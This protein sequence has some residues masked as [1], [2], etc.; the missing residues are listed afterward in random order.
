MNAKD[1]SAIAQANKVIKLPCKPG[2][3]FEDL[4]S[5]GSKAKVDSLLLKFEELA[6]QGFGSVTIGLDGTSEMLM[7][8]EGTGCFYSESEVIELLYGLGFRLEKVNDY[9]DARDYKTSWDNNL[10]HSKDTVRY[11]I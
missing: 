6:K 3:T 5:K 11:P 8:D 2:E 9:Y 10:P 1:L 7:Q 4:I